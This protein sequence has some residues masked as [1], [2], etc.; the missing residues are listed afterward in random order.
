[1]E[2]IHHLRL[3]SDELNRLFP[4]SAEQPMSSGRREVT[5]PIG[6]GVPSL[7]RRQPLAI[8]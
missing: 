4:Q 6:H 7:D 1:M 8:S 5:S 2:K 3:G